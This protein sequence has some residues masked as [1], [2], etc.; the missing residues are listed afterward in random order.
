MATTMRSRRPS[1]RVGAFITRPRRV[2]NLMESSAY[3][4]A[5]QNQPTHNVSDRWHNF[6]TV[7][8]SCEPSGCHSD[9]EGPVDL[10]T[11]GLQQGL[12]EVALPGNVD[13]VEPEPA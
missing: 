10:S 2:T 8:S 9:I 1:V 7:L 11:K 12:G 3:V 5:F 13:G 6:C 4:S